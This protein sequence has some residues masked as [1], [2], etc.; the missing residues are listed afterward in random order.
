V[1]LRLSD[2]NLFRAYEQNKDLQLSLQGS[3]NILDS[4]EARMLQDDSLR[5]QVANVAGVPRIAVTTEE[6]E[7][8][9]V[10]ADPYGLGPVKYLRKIR[11]AHKDFQ[12]LRDT[13][14]AHANYAASLPVLYPIRKHQDITSRFELVFDP[15]VDKPVPHQALDFAASL[16]DTVIA[17]GAGM[18]ASVISDRSYGL[19]VTILHNSRMET[20][21]AHLDRALVSP[22]QAVKRGQPIALIGSSGLSSG[23]HLHYEMRF[24]GQRVNPA[25]Y[26]ITP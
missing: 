5:A 26:F 24:E 11:K 1:L 21:Y 3:T 16:G 13:L 8:L 25:D 7:K 18:V 19:S 23:P 14:L 20:F 9:E 6:G 17:P 10:H 22:G 15:R 2:G 12:L 4:L